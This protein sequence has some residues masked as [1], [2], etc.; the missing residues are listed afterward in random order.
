MRHTAG[1]IATL[2]GLLLVI[3]ILVHF[4]PSP[5]PDRIGKWLPSQAGQA[6]FTVRPEGASLSPWVGYAVLC[7]WAA[8]ALVAAAVLL[9]R[10][11]A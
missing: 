8:A 1:A 2:F 6:L 4:L 9:V 5:W 10:R 11:D 7:A 3:P